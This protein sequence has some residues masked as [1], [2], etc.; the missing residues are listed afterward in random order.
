MKRVAWS[1]NNNRFCCYVVQCRSKLPSRYRCTAFLLCIT[2]AQRQCN[3]NGTVAKSHRIGLYRTKARGCSFPSVRQMFSTSNNPAS[4]GNAVD[5]R[6]RLLFASISFR[7]RVNP[8]NTSCGSNVAFGHS[9]RMST[10]TLSF[11]K[12]HGRNFGMKLVER[13]G[14][15]SLDRISSFVEVLQKR[16]PP[17]RV[18][19][20]AISIFREGIELVPARRSTLENAELIL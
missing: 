16:S 18:F 12:I 11:L 5:S 8:R 14:V 9:Q 6:V 2:P 20:L 3:D 17:S 7:R 15:T 10:C 19:S 4:I 13:E 1:R